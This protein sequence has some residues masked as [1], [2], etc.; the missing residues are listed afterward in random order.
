MV[1]DVAQTP[2]LA[3]VYIPCGLGNKVK[4]GDLTDR[5]VVTEIVQNLE[6]GARV[7]ECR[8]DRKSFCPLCPNPCS[9]RLG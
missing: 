4:V 5:G 6:Y 2:D 8:S 9:E 3:Q 1:T 7:W